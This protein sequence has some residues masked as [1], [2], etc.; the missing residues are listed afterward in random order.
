MSTESIFSWWVK[1]LVVAH[2]PASVS[3][4]L[5]SLLVLLMNFS[6]LLK[7]ITLDTSRSFERIFL[8]SWLLW[9]GSRRPD[10]NLTGPTSSLLMIMRAHCTDEDPAF[11]WEYNTK[12]LSRSSTNSLPTSELCTSASLAVKDYSVLSNP[13][14]KIYLLNFPRVASYFQ[15]HHWGQSSGSLSTYIW[16]VFSECM[17]LCV[18]DMI[19]ILTSFQ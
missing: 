14:F 12:R 4:H 7:E 3:P 2:V 6:S 1:F 17:T 16:V 15:H 5:Q 11:Q 9:M 8:C 18:H 13:Q 10:S 19:S